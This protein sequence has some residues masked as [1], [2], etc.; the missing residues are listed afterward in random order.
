MR[1][2]TQSL[3][4]EDTIL[5]AYTGFLA[6][7]FGWLVCF[8]VGRTQSYPRHGISQPPKEPGCFTG[9]W[10]LEIRTR[11]CL[12]ASKVLWTRCLI[13][14]HTPPPSGGH[15]VPSSKCTLTLLRNQVLSYSETNFSVW[16]AK[17]DRLEKYHMSIRN[18]SVGEKPN[19]KTAHESFPFPT[20]LK[21]NS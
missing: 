16:L 18:H 10:Y 12:T 3:S 17:E 19:A 5:V 4:P 1:T 21:G 20:E 13:G 14:T 9:E 2:S 8:L 11:N 6:W 15:H 7:L